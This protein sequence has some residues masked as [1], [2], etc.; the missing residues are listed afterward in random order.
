MIPFCGRCGL[1]CLVVV[2]VGFVCGVGAH[3]P[4]LAMVVMD[5]GGKGSSMSASV[6]CFLCCGRGRAR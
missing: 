2:G 4:V 1:L 3:S 6:S 5:L